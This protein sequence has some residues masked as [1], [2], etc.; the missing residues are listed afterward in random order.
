MY[1]P[2]DS[3]GHL[4]GPVQNQVER[5]E[6]RTLLEGRA[7]LVP[8]SV[9]IFRREAIEAV[10]PFRQHLAPADDYD[11][12]LR[13]AHRFPIHCHN[14]VI[15][16]YRQHGANNSNKVAMMLS[17]TERALDAQSEITCGDP[18]LRAACA[19]GKSYWRKLFGPY[20]AYEMAANI[21]KGRLPAAVRVMWVMVRKYPRGFPAYLSELAGKLLGL[22]GGAGATDRA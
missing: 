6:F 11:L 2:I 3:L 12:Y 16:E 17:L 1:W 18:Q 7:S 22:S 8:P 20:L 14:Q 15:V 10:G 9:A 4:N 19:R 5:A 21:K 13:L